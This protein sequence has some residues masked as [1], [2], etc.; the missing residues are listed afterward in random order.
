MK[1]L[2]RSCITCE[3]RHKHSKYSSP[4][5]RY[6]PPTVSGDHQHGR[7]PET[8]DEA[9]CSKWEPKWIENP[10]LQE[11]WEQFLMVHKIITSGEE[12]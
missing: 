9:Y 5:C 7:F 11:A 12:E 4:V 1:N 3:Y 10:V 8:Y 2:E 6:N